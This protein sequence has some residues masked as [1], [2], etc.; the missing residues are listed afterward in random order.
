MLD[1]HYVLPR[2]AAFYDIECGWSGDRDFYLAL[3]GQAPSRVLDL[4][5]GTGLLCE[6]YAAAGHTVSGVDP[7]GA[8]LAVGRQKP[9]GGAIDWVEAAASEFRSD[10][11][12]DLIIMTGHAFQVL[13]TDAD[14]AAVLQVMHDH[15]APNG[16]AVF[17]VRNPALD[18][19]RRWTYER[20]TIALPAGGE[21]EKWGMVLA[22]N[23]ERLRFEQ[24]YRFPDGEV[25]ASVSELRFA[26]RETILR[27]AAEAGLELVELLGDWDGSEYDPQRSEEMIF[28]FGRA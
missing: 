22:R 13:L 25:V 20:T 1:K 6:A 11:R 15:L 16:R 14:I 24:R 18:W 3:A 12:F 4:G 10:K 7:A 2:M 26:P 17:E 27:L 5:C 8:M 9:Y 19:E 21:V 23:G 28:V